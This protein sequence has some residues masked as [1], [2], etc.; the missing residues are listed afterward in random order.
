M[1]RFYVKKS[2][3]PFP[4][5]GDDTTYFVCDRDNEIPDKH[6]NRYFRSKSVAQASANNLNRQH[7]APDVVLTVQCPLCKATRDLRASDGPHND[8]PLCENDGMPMM[9]RRARSAVK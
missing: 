7:A 3:W 1:N 6:N 5:A 2:V 4:V 8:V 9:P